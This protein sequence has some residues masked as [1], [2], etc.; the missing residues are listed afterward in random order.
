MIFVVPPSATYRDF[1][2]PVISTSFDDNSKALLKK[3]ENLSPDNEIKKLE[4]VKMVDLYP[5][6]EIIGDKKCE[7]MDLSI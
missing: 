4:R 3:F 5:E 2:S 7:N 6:K 1:C